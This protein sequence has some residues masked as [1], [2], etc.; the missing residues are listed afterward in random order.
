MA[1]QRVV[2]EGGG[3]V[4]RAGLGEMP[5]TLFVIVAGIVLFFAIRRA[6]LGIDLHPSEKVTVKPKPAPKGAPSYGPVYIN[7]TVPMFS[8]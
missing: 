1:Y 3:S 8:Y 6:H 4:A 2:T 5:L 7:P